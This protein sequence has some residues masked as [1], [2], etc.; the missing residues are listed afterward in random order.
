MH[1]ICPRH[2]PS[3][4]IGH[5]SPPQKVVV[6][7]GVIALSRQLMAYDSNSWRHAER[8][9]HCRDHAEDTDLRAKGSIVDV[10][11]CRRSCAVAP[12]SRAVVCQLRGLGKQRCTNR[13]HVEIT[14]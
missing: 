14:C 6:G 12:D 10:V 11:V 13:K 2:G 9:G 4:Q 1:S 3:N 5:K 8:S 7:W